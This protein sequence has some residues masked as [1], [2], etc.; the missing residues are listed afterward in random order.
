MVAHRSAIT[1]L[2]WGRFCFGIALRHASR[3]GARFAS[4]PRRGGL[5]R[6]R[7][8]YRVSVRDTE[9]R[10]EEAENLLLKSE[11]SEIPKPSPNQCARHY[12]TQKVHAEQNAR[13]GDTEGA[14]QQPDGKGRIK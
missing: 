8:P 9:P 6:Q 12:V 4:R 5:P 2:G 11:V 3:S 13:H 7:L 1:R 10:P 14:E